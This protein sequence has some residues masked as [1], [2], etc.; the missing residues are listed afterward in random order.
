MS[1]WYSRIWVGLLQKEVEGNH[2]A[3]H[4]KNKKI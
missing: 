3:S 2:V 1:V 4:W